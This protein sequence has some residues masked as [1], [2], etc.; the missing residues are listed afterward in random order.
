MLLKTDFK[1]LDKPTFLATNVIGDTIAF[2]SWKA[3]YHVDQEYIE[4]ENIN[5]LHIADA[6]IQP[7]QGKLTINR[8][9]KINQLQNAIV[10]INNKHLLHS[11]KIDI[12]STRDTAEAVFTTMWMRTKRYRT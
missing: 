8:R 2:S 9:A 1:N 7:E 12:E 6:L 11:A 4:A 5:Y 10:A 3:R